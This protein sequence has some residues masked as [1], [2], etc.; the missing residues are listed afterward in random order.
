MEVG[1]GGGVVVAGGGGS[2]AGEVGVD[3]LPEL[4]VVVGKKVVR[5]GSWRSMTVLRAACSASGSSGP[6][7]VAPPSMW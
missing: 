7:M 3:D 4:V 6:V 5:R 1:V 2:G